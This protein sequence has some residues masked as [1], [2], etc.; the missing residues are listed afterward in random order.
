MVDFISYPSNMHN[1]FE[2]YSNSHEQPLDYP[3]TAQPFMP[4]STYGMEQTFSAPYDPMVP[5]A[6]A[7]RP[8]DLQ[9]H[10]DA[11]AQ[12]VKPFQ[13]HTP[14]GSPHSTSHSFHEQPP[15]LSASS[16]SGASVS[17]STMGSPTQYNEPWNPM[18][19]GLTSSFEYQGMIA[20]EKTFVGE[21]TVLSAVSSSI[22][23]LISPTTP[24]S[25]RKVFKTPIT[26]ASANW[27]IPRP[28]GR[29]NSLLSH[30]VRP[31]DVIPTTISP[32]I[33]SSARS[34]QPL[35]S[36]CWFPIVASPCYKHQRLTWCKQIPI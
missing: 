21:S 24:L 11:I 33:D 3:L 26:P 35:D 7:S 5:L 10:Y 13:F 25:E 6:E 29:R 19:L 14:A 16:E 18:G 9:F 1:D 28:S 27:S 31:C 22:S 23:S 20:A 2:L 36:P 12:G 34:F 4:S 8:H 32:L 15:V 17:S 30:I